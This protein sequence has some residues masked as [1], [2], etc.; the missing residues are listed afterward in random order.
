M[1]WQR[2][3]WLGAALLLNSLAGLVAL[4]R[5]VW[6]DG[7]DGRWRFVGLACVLV[8]AFVVYFEVA[9]RA[10]QPRARADRPSGGEVADRLNN[11]G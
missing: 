3:L 9:T 10:G 7:V 2:R 1:W 8:E 11:D 4:W 6:R 5:L